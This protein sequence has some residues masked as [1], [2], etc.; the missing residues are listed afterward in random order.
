MALKVD[1]QESGRSVDNPFMT[2]GRS[3][4][5]PWI[6][7]IYRSLS[8]EYTRGPSIFIRKDR[9]VSTLRIADL[10]DRPI[11]LLL[12]R[13]VWPLLSTLTHPTIRCDLRRST[14]AVHSGPLESGG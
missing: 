5:D 8:S 14:Q 2:R 10:T 6:V 13:L 11:L 9:P 7:H 1:G 3:V 12:E 4:D